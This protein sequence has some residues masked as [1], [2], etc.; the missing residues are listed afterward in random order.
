MGAGGGRGR[1]GQAQGCLWGPVRA[2]IGG[3]VSLQPPNA[4]TWGLR[5]PYRADLDECALREDRCSLR[6]DCLN[7][8]GSYRC[9]CRHGFTGDGFSCD[10][11]SGEGPERDSHLSL[12]PQVLTAVSGLPDLPRSLPTPHAG[13]LERMHLQ[14]VGPQARPSVTGGGCLLPQTLDARSLWMW[15]AGTLAYFPGPSTWV[16]RHQVPCLPELGSEFPVLLACSLEPWVTTKG[17]T[18][19]TCPLCVGPGQLAPSPLPLGVPQTGTN[20]LRTWTSART[21][22]ASMPP[23]G[24]AAS[25]RWASAPQRTTAPAGV[26]PGAAGLGDAAGGP[27]GAAGAGCQVRWADLGS[28]QM[29]TSVF[30]GTSACSGA[31]RTCPECSAVCAVAAMSWTAVGATA[32]VGGQPGC[33]C[34][35]APGSLPPCPQTSSRMS[36]SGGACLTPHH[37]QHPN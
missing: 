26:R 20:V 10:G 31:A 2:K 9:V 13:V 3:S 28:P 35:R 27:R 5:A 1:A 8:P 36:C 19:A 18:G 17:L 30:S 34:G 16:L 29:W 4:H 12:D 14:P 33:G 37:Q 22:S 21:G 11:E 7:A 25:V 6:A 15:G 23:A 24:T 32:Q